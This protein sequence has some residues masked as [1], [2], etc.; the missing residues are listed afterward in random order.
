MHKFCACYD[1]NVRIRIISGGQF[2][3]NGYGGRG[4][5]VRRTNGGMKPLPEGMLQDL[6]D[7]WR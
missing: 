4:A 6:D 2:D 3:Y 1:I 5:P 7:L